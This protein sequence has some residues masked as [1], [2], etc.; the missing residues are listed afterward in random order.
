MSSATASMFHPRRD[1]LR[2]RANMAL[3]RGAAL[4]VLVHAGLL[5]ALSGS[6]HWRTKQEAVFAAELWAAVPQLAAPPA[7]V[8]QVAPALPPPSPPPKLAPAPPPPP[9]PR[10]AQIAVEKTKPAPPLPP[11]PKP[12]PEPPK[13]DKQAAKPAAK[14]VAKVEPKPDPKV[15]RDKEAAA[16][17]ERQRLDDER[18]ARQ[19]EEN[20]KR[21]LN[22]VG[23]GTATG[24]A[25]QG[26]ASQDAAP[27][28]SYAGRL[29]ARIFPNILFTE[30]VASNAAADV[31]VRLAP[32]GTVVSRRLVKSSGN[33]DW[34][35][36]VLRAIDKTR[37]LPRDTDGR[38][39]PAVIVTFKPRPA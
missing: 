1:A 39:P 14:P 15:A 25:P 21:M 32:D 13:P 28:A 7:P 23:A 18:L 3:G 26:Q 29:V 9:P 27:S 33:P 6:L 38:V 12:E 19:R 31:E 5:L 16:E 20:L 22:Q 34:D 11:K 30:S 8:A 10:E 24:A 37:V 17:R 4:A 36:A 2:P 35:E